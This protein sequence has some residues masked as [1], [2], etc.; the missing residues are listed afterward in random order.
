MGV[1]VICPDCPPG[2]LKVVVVDVDDSSVKE[3]P[4]VAEKRALM[5]AETSIEIVS[6]SDCSNVIDWEQPWELEQE[7]TSLT[8]L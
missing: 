6:E 1:K 8:V 5:P 4:K 7:V 2:M 3:T